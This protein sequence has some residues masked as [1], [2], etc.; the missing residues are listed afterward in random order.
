MY[1][2]PAAGTRGIVH[3]KALEIQGFLRWLPGVL[4][5]GNVSFPPFSS[6]VLAGADVQ[7]LRLVQGILQDLP[8]NSSRA[9]EAA[10]QR[11]WYISW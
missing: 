9:R 3:K 1:T 11:M 8:G 4:K 5:G 2:V 10:A 6:G 7:L